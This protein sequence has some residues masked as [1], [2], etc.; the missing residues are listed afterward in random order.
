[1]EQPFFTSIYMKKITKKEFIHKAKNIHL[2]NYDYSLVE[3]K[4]AKTK[5][6]I[7]CP[8]HEIFEQ[9]PDSHLRGNGCPKCG[10]EK[11]S[12]KQRMSYEKFIEKAKIIHG[13]RYDYSLVEYINAKTKIKIICPIHGI[14]EQIPDNHTT[15]KYGCPFCR[16]SQG[17]KEIAK[18]L[19]EMNISFERQ[20]KFKDCKNKQCLPF[21]FY[22]PKY[23]I[24]I[25]YQGVQHFK[26]D[27]F[28]NRTEEELL[29][30][31]H[32]D[33]IKYDYCVNNHINI[34]FINYDDEIKSK[35]LSFP[36]MLLL[37]EEA[38]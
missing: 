20:K 19:T 4:N 8:I 10:L 16:E 24:C 27:G 5:V 14:F 35:L 1:M 23:N 34:L 17:E 9:T 30:R 22:I 37:N 2:I 15:K 31:N 29:L 25:E 28:I 3:Y 7:I 12:K 36:N 13:D 6:K 38:Q 18:I 32:L 21:D 26:V 33:K 11:S